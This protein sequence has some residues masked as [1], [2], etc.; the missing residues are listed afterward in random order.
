MKL[1]LG[2][3]KPGVVGRTYQCWASVSHDPLFSA[4]AF[5]RPPQTIE[6]DNRNVWGFGNSLEFAVKR[7]VSEFCTIL[8]PIWKLD[9]F[10]RDAYFH[11][12]V[13]LQQN[14]LI[15]PR[16]I[17]SKEMH[18]FYTVVYFSK[19]CMHC[20]DIFAEQNPRLQRGSGVGLSIQSF[21]KDVHRKTSKEQISRS[22]LITN[23]PIIP[24]RFPLDET[25]QALKYCQTRVQSLFGSITI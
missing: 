22:R 17:Y 3:E 24:H 23:S 1:R 10:Y 18:Y 8:Q 2:D 6:I 11:R 7:P 9:I 19:R 20:F 4:R 15:F 25:S 5:R 13:N 16:C 12:Y 21:G 14:L